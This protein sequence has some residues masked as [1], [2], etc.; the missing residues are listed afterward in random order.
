[1][2]KLF[3]VVFSKVKGIFVVC[4]E[5]GK[6]HGRSKKLK[7]SV[8]A[9]TAVV[10]MGVTGN[11][12][13]VNSPIEVASGKT[14]EAPKDTVGYDSSVG[15]MDY[16]G[17]NGGVF[18]N[19]GTLNINGANFGITNSS[20]KAKFGGAIYNS[21]N[22]RLN[23]SGTSTFTGNEAEES[24]GAVYN[25]KGTV[26]FSSTSKNTF[27]GNK[28]SMWGGAIYNSNDATLVLSGR[29]EFTGNNAMLGGAIYNRA[30]TAEI[31]GT[32]TFS[33][34]NATSVAG[35]IYN[36]GSYDEYGTVEISGENEFIKNSASNFG[37]AIFNGQ[38]GA[39]VKISG[40][41]NFA[42]NI[43]AYGGAIFNGWQGTLNISGTNTFTGNK[44]TIVG[45]KDEN[46]GCGCA[47][48]N[49]AG[50]VTLPGVI[51]SGT[52]TFTGNT[53]ATFGEAI[54]NKWN[55]VLTLSGTNTFYNNEDSSGPND[56]YNNKGGQG[57]IIKV[58][59]GITILGSCLTNLSNV[60]LTGGT[61][62]MGAG[63][64]I[65]GDGKIHIQGGTLDISVMGDNALTNATNTVN[66]TED[67]ETNT[68]SG[69]IQVVSKQIFTTELGAYD[70]TATDYGLA[71]NP[72]SYI[73][74]TGSTNISDLFTDKS[75]ATLALADDY[76]NVNYINGVRNLIKTTGLSMLGTL[77]GDTTISDL[78][79][80]NASITSSIA[81][82]SASE[83]GKVN[84]VVGAENTDDLIGTDY[85]NAETYNNNLAAKVLKLTTEGSHKVLVTGE[86]SLTLRGDG[87]NL[88]TVNSTSAPIIDVGHEMLGNGTLN[89]IQFQ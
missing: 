46:G 49:N 40:K 21:E 41:N 23:F 38:H 1:M 34:N 61:L 72:D 44:A 83:T 13:A 45:T 66:F 58:I 79:G 50:D 69:A 56:I 82:V 10:L 12:V 59:D 62:A 26:E 11:A 36:Y 68:Y 5:L 57:G 35:A 16:S 88:L 86:K 28:V 29:N 51:L 7:A 4:S 27:I 24:G 30:G 55:S 52:N 80:A 2:N 25:D 89:F 70:A 8:T 60:Y 17:T 22:A 43:G 53:V 14:Y 63:T 84:L 37:A 33:G 20:N 19:E 42:N 15:Y 67:S 39:T 31:S 64:A 75:G 47:I 9:L 76:Y 32:N 81:N 3:K 71:S 18:Y 87:E 85:A 78:A 77:V 74:S 48:R 54:Y 73:N 65:K 6:S